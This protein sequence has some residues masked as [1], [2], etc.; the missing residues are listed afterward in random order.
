MSKVDKFKSISEDNVVY[1]NSPAIDAEY[2][3]YSIIYE[4]TNY[5][6]DDKLVFLEPL[7]IYNPRLRV[8]YDNLYV[9]VKVLNSPEGWTDFVKVNTL[10][11]VE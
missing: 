11:I 6:N 7:D 10:K 5:G 9:E 1:V 3:V 2:S 4:D 8:I